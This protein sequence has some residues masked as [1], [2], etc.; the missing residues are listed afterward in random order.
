MEKYENKQKIVT[1]LKILV[2]TALITLNIYVIYN[3]IELNKIN[4]SKIKDKHIEKEIKEKIKSLIKNGDNIEIYQEIDQEQI[5]KIIDHPI[6]KKSIEDKVSKEIKFLNPKIEQENNKNNGNIDDIKEKLDKEQQLLYNDKNHNTKFFP[7][8]KSNFIPYEKIIGMDKEKEALEEFLDYLQNPENY[9]DEK[10]GYVE[11]PKGVILYGCPGT[12][13]TLLARSLSLKA[14]DQVSFYEIASPEFS[15]SLVGE[16]PEKVRN[17][18]KDVRNN[19]KKNNIKAS[20]I[21]IDECE[22]IFKNLSNMGENS[23]KDLGNI[24]NQFKIELT[25]TEND[26]KKPIFIIGATNY[27]EQID[28]AIKSRLDYHIEVKTLNKK[29]RVFFL[30]NRIKHR[31]NNFEKNA[32]KY[33]LEDINNEIDKYPEVKRSNRVLDQLLNSIMRNAAKDKRNIAQ[34][35]DIKKAFENIYN[36]S[37]N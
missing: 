9:S 29:D 26:P 15:C 23:N 14:G 12:G 13:K 34:K 25:S 31:K 30:E 8:N 36:S 24:V 4:N 21:F 32:L 10:L 37:K 2:I 28:E 35:K 1:I 33:L 22:E 7:K 11:N 20:I 18:F 6:I 16:S 3:N 5:E 27:F 19:N 17:L